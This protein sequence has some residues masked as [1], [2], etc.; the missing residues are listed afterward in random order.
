MNSILDCIREARGYIEQGWCR[1]AI[2]RN[3]D[4][5]EVPWRDEDACEWCIL[6]AFRKAQWWNHT[7]LIEALFAAMDEA[8]DD[9]N[10][11]PTRTKQDVLDLMDR[12]ASDLAGSS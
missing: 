9:W 6:G 8:P 5:E 10:D 11:N 12:L 4:G 2:A 7:E 3:R 1:G